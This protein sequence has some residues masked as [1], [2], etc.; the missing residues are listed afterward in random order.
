MFCFTAEEDESNVQLYEKPVPEN[1][2]VIHCIQRRKYP[3]LLK[4]CYNTN[5]MQI[6]YCLAFANYAT[7]LQNFEPT[8]FGM[9]CIFVL[10]ETPWHGPYIICFQMEFNN[11]VK[12]NNQHSL[13]HGSKK[14]NIEKNQ[15]PRIIPCKY[16]SA[17]LKQNLGKLNCPMHSGQAAFLYKSE[18]S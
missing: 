11:A 16:F 7:Y 2:F 3:V 8:Q 4:V 6:S 15:N 14:A 9:F 18:I 12:E 5:K 13:R 1:D 17:P 10:L